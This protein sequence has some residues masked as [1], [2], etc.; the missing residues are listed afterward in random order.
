MRRKWIFMA[1]LATL[2]ILLFIF[3]GG[4]IVMRL[5][6]WLLPPLFGWREITFW[7]A[8]GLLVLCR[9]LFGGFGHHGSHR[10]GLPS[11]VRRR[12]QERCGQMTPEERE[13]FRQRVQARWGCGPSAGESKE[14]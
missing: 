14:P 5:W 10:A 2:G 12:M 11:R 7:Q 13:R 8:L 4:E 9:I 6:N 3:I 1:P